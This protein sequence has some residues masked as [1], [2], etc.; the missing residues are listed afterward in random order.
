LPLIVHAV[1]YDPTYDLNGD[2]VIDGKDIVA[3]ATHF[4]SF[5][6]AL[7]APP[8]FIDVYPASQYWMTGGDDLNPLYRG[9]D[10]FYISSIPG[11]PSG[12]PSRT[13][14][15]LLA[16]THDWIVYDILTTASGLLNAVNL[17]LRN[18]E[19]PP[20]TPPYSTLSENY[21]PVSVWVWNG[22]YPG[23]V[24]TQSHDMDLDTTVFQ[25]I[26]SVNITYPGTWS[27]FN[28]PVSSSISTTLGS[29]NQYYI[30]VRLDNGTFYTAGVDRNV[31]IGWVQLY[32][33]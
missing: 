32:I 22:T 11:A 6:P 9:A 18:L 29:R 20:N 8:N 28:L 19:T 23:V 7:P 5:T 13:Y 31:E 14:S 24:P 16:H 33:S 17:T 3:V 26:G 25:Q 15:V 12:W 21:T 30:A 2:S 27:F 1:T 4:G 10:D